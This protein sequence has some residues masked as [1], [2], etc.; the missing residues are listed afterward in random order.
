MY[1]CALLTDVNNIPWVCVDGW[2][3]FMA[4]I[5]NVNMTA[6]DI[7]NQIKQEKSNKVIVRWGGTSNEP[8]EIKS[9]CWH[10]TL[11][12]EPDL[13]FKEKEEMYKNRATHCTKVEVESAEEGV[14]LYYELGK[15]LGNTDMQTP[16]IGNVDNKKLLYLAIHIHYHI[17]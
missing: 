4:T 2:P 3:N 5:K 9:E 17:Q 14:R 15:H 6:E 7:I 11:T 10:M 13:Y 8:I 16:E 12:D 1:L